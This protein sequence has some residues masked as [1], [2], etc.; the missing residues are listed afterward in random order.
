MPDS[1]EGNRNSLL[2][3][4]HGAKNNRSFVMR[5]NEIR[6]FRHSEEGNVEYAATIKDLSFKKMSGFEPAHVSFAVYP[7]HLLY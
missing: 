5:G 7:E 2:A 4:G 3:V 6:V 1:G